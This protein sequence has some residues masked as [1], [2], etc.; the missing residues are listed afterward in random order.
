MSTTY[1]SLLQKVH[2]INDIDR[3]NAVL[4]WDREVNMPKAGL[5]ERVAQMTT[6]SRLSHE[7]FTADEMGELIAA[8]SAELNG[9]SYDSDE[10]SLLRLLERTYADARK[11][12]PEHVTRSSEV[13]GL[14]HRAWVQAREEN[15]F[16]S[17]R[18][19]LE[20]VIELC[21]E[22]AGLYGYEDEPYDAL[23]DKY[24][25]DMKTAEVRAI[26]DALKADL[27]PLREAI[28]ASATAVDD[29]LLHRPYPIEKQQ[30]FARYIAS[31]LGYDFE[32]GHLG[33]VVHPFSITFSRNDSRI[34]TRWYP[35]DLRASLFGTMHESGHSMYEQ[36]T[37]P[38][39][40]RTPL[41]RGTSLGVHESQSR[42]MENIVGR[43]R[44]WWEVHFPQ[45]QATFP[46]QLSGNTADEFYRAINKVQPSFIRVEA[47]EL[48][49]NFHI[50]LRFELEQA[51]LN[52][53]LAARDLPEAWNARM[54]ELLGIVPPT[55]TLGCLQDVHW[56][57]PGFGYFPTYALGNLYA[58]QWFET[59]MVED[60]TIIEEMTQ[61]KTDALVAWLRENI[62][63][64]GRKF[65]PRELVQRVTGRP[66]SHDAFIRYANAKFGDIYGLS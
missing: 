32:R 25:T 48:T 39:L 28:D 10:A 12:T 23:L 53:E 45:L 46:E 26:F 64:H 18:P 49:Y 35:D 56:T 60:P 5:Q 8:A 65:T 47:D 55:D 44:G 62:H 36:G 40:S 37:A 58:T 17:F 34:T 59:A 33:T 50:I 51:M 2:Q 15:D 42:M 43:S 41:A 22:R 30:A 3:A 31:A 61:G 57:R 21:Q 11:L 63:R 4:A 1:D 54:E 7:M 20:Q 14:A 66:L 19:W 24:E 16:E 13:G 29:S 52:G 9:A 38:E 27:V 6:L